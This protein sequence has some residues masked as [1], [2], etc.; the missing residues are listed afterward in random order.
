MCG[1]AALVEK[2]KNKKKVCLFL[3]Y[4]NS[5]EYAARNWTNGFWNRTQCRRALPAASPK[6][7]ALTRS[8]WPMPECR[9]RGFATS[10]PEDF[11]SF[12]TFDLA[13]F[14]RCRPPLQIRQHTRSRV[15]PAVSFVI[16]STTG[17]TIS[18]WPEKTSARG[19]S[20]Y[21]KSLFHVILQINASRDAVL[22]GFHMRLTSGEARAD[23]LRCRQIVA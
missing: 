13:G 14:H 7:Q 2:K 5:C 1:I 19:P 8:Y 3:C 9:C 12:S 22:R 10:P 17:F 16:Y 18:C 21:D 6:I 11:P 20:I 23:V 15:E 4:D